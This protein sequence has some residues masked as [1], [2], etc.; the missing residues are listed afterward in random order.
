MLVFGLKDLAMRVKMLHNKYKLFLILIAF[1]LF[2]VSCMSTLCP[3]YTSQAV[4]NS[5]ELART[6]R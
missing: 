5:K 3:A 4:Y 6:L 1:M 2:M